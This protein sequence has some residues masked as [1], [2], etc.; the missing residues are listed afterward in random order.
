MNEN[1]NQIEAD[2]ITE[3]DG[4]V[5]VYTV[6]RLE[7]IPNK[8][9]I[10]LVHLKDCGYTCITEKIHKVGD[11]VVFIKYDTIVP[12]N[13]LFEFMK[14]TKFRVKQ[15][16]FTE[17]D[18][19]DFVI[20]KI[21]S[22]GI[23]L[24]LSKVREEVGKTFDYQN[25]EEDIFE[26]GYDLTQ[27]LNIKKYIKPPSKG[28]GMGNMC[29]KG[30]FPVDKV[31]KTD[32]VNLASKV[33]LL[34]YLQGKPYEISL[35]YEGSSLTTMWDDDKNE[36][37]VCSRNN[38]LG[39]SESNK[40]WQAVNKYNLKEKLVNSIYII[41][42]EL[43]GTGVQRNKLQLDGIELRSFRIVNKLTRE[44]IAEDVA[45]K[46]SEEY[47]IPWKKIIDKGNYFNYTFDQLQKLSDNQRYD[48]SGELAEGIVLR[49][50]I[51]TPTRGLGETFSCK[52]LNRE[53]KL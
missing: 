52:I 53:Y 11:K 48:E 50:V 39:E 29:S 42:A 5:V 30:D 43:V 16:A 2:E 6:E 3:R 38:Q 47:G 7:A 19:E 13:E 18:D 51:P 46:I 45:K 24:P 34:E 33:R 9:R 15:K 44:L 21:Y 26:E 31:S 10:E 41:S 17:R 25:I 22:Q 20:K 28:E 49:S 40:F 35:K 4:L 1:L 32:E 14:E 8:D 37:M 36:L 27:I 23:V 12:N